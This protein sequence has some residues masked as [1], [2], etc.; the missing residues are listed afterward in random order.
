LARREAKAVKRNA[1]LQTAAMSRFAGEVNDEATND[2]PG[3][4]PI[5]GVLDLHTFRPQDLGD[6]VPDYLAECRARGI[7]QVRVIH[8]KGTGQVKRS[9]HAILSR[10]PDV[11]SFNE[12]GPHF[13]G[14]GATIVNL[15]R[16]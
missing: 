16:L 13:G 9:V 10:L 1:T 6:L 14:A 5:D 4:L 7:L 15:R 11:A 8:G 2:A 3:E 12:A